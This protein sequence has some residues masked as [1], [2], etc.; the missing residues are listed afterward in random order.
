MKWEYISHTCGPENRMTVA[1]LNERGQSG[2]QLVSAIPDPDDHSC[3][4][5]YF[6]RPVEEEKF[7]P[8]PIIFGLICGMVFGFLILAVT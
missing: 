1:D 2:W 3:V 6:K 8:R 7:N 4:I 5:Y